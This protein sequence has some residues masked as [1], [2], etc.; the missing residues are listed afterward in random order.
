MSDVFKFYDAWASTYDEPDFLLESVIPL[1]VELA[2]EKRPTRAL[3]VGAGTGKI[4]SE[5]LSRGVSVLAI[6][7]SEGM[8]A[9]L[10]RRCASSIESGQLTIEPVDLA[11]F[12]SRGRAFDL[13]VVSMVI[14]HLPTVDPVFSLAAESIKDGGRLVVSCV[15]PYY[16]MIVRRGMVCRGAERNVA[17]EEVM[18]P[19]SVPA[20]IHSFGSIIDAARRSGFMMTHL[21]EA[22]IDSTLVD[23]FPALQPERGYFHVFSA[24]FERFV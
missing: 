18:V 21:R 12:R 7:P 8:R 5:L 22:T 10:Q 24:S 13:M 19:Q 15:N 11:S 14:D 6:E 16:Q 2:A 3:E 17:P 1:T 23:K 4:T 9:V 20:C